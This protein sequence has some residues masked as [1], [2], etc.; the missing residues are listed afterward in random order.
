MGKNMRLCL[1]MTFL[2]FFPTAVLKNDGGLHKLHNPLYRDPELRNSNFELF[3]Q[4]GENF[5]KLCR[6]LTQH[7]LNGN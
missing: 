3:D 6:V 2:H 1:Y 7:F 4:E 5:S